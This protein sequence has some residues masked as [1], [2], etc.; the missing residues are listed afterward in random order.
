MK[1]DLILDDLKAVE[2]A[3][4]Y[5]NSLL[6]VM[7]SY[8][9]LINDVSGLLEVSD[10]LNN[11]SRL[12]Y[13]SMIEMNTSSKEINLVTL[14]DNL[15]KKSQLSTIGGIS[16]VAKIQ[17][18]GGAK[19]NSISYA[20]IIKKNSTARQLSAAGSQIAEL[21]KAKGDIENNI[22]YA[23]ELISKVETN[24]SKKEDFFRLKDLILESIE[25]LDNKLFADPVTL[26]GVTSG[27]IELDDKI[28]NLKGGDLIVVAGRPSM[29]K[30]VLGMQVALFVSHNNLV[31]R[32]SAVFSLEMT[33]ETLS[34]RAISQV[35]G[36]PLKGIIEGTIEDGEFDKLSVAG[37]ELSESEM[38][39]NDDAGLTYQQISI[40]AKKLAKKLENTEAP[41]G[42]I[43]IDYLQIMGY[44]GSAIQRD[45]Q[46][47][48]MSRGLKKLAKD[49]NVP[50]ILLAQINRGVESRVDKRPLMSDLRES[51]AIEQDADIIIMCYREDYYDP[52]TEY[53]GIAEMLIRKNRNGETGVVKLRFEGECVR[54]KNFNSVW[55][56]PED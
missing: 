5:E 54:F 17:Q 24:S 55:N 15:D 11:S 6:G 47:G 28:G 13:S 3:T 50:V 22:A 46:I 41:L 45:A 31:K 39:L 20:D 48:E 12:I 43:V 40:K 26:G 16:A 30:T 4:M 25:D 37:K 9:S 23:N 18:N 14:L 44:A 27:F 8:P 52:D 32:S 33:K 2:V 35:S 38:W 51:G 36:I 7:I 21:G 10:F 42:V 56:G 1:N 49:L 34:E 29:G 53:K 19:E